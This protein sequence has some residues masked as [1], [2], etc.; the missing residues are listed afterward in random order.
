[1]TPC[2]KASVLLLLPPWKVGVTVGMALCAAP[3][4]R[5]QLSDG[6]LIRDSVMLRRKG[7]AWK[8]TE[9][10]QKRT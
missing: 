2:I 3:A 5:V 6:R 9:Q 1:M 8:K 10:E 4:A 7:Y